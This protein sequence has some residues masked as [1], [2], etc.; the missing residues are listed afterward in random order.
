MNDRQIRKEGRRKRRLA[1]AAGAPRRP[2]SFG[3]RVFLFFFKAGLTL[4]MLLALVAGGA[5]MAIEAGALD[6]TLKARAEGALNGAVGPRYLA[7]VGSTAIR[8]AHNRQIAI[9]ARKVVMKDQDTGRVVSETGAIRL[10]LDPF[11]LFQGEL[12][13]TR[14][15]ADNVRF[16]TAL[17]STGEGLDLTRARVD[18][19]P[20][21][22]DNG[23]AQLD[24]FGGFIDRARTDALEIRGMELLAAGPDGKDLSVGKA[25]F[26]LE[27]RDDSSLRMDGALDIKGDAVPFTILAERRLGKVASLKASVHEVPLLHFGP[28]PDWRGRTEEKLDAT[29]YAEISAIRK[30]QDIFPEITLSARVNPGT[31]TLH[32]IDQKL[33]GATVEAVYDF[34]KNSVEF[35]PSSV[36]FGETNLPFTGGLIDL[37]RIRPDA[38]KGFGIDFLV[39]GGKVYTEG[40]GAAPADMDAQASGYYL[41]ADQELVFDQMTASTRLG[42]IIGSMKMKFGGKEPE[43]SFVA[44]TPSA[45]MQTVKQ[46]WPFWIA[47]NARQWVSD[48]LFAGSVSNGSI[49]VFVPADRQRNADGTL[50]LSDDQL[51]INFDVTNARVN[52]AGDIPPLRGTTGHIQLKGA[53]LHAEIKSGTSYFPTDRSVNIDGGTFSIPD[54]SQEPLM[55]E[56]DVTVSGAA[57]AVAEL[58]TYRPIKFLGRTGLKPEDLAGNIRAHVKARF[59]L[60]SEDDVDPTWTADMALTNVD[61]MKPVQGRR[62][63]GLTG[64][65]EVTPAEA[66]LEAKGEV[67]GVPMEL[68]ATE[69]FD[70]AQRARRERLM[71]LTLDTAD[72]ARLFPNLEQVV[73]GPVKAKVSL[74]EDGVQQVEADLVAATLKVPGSGWTKGAGIPAR[75][76]FEVHPSEDRVE[77]RNLA[78]EGDG[79]GVAG[80]IE[81]RN[82][83]LIVA[84]FDRVKLA[85]NDNFALTVRPIRSGFD[86][87]VSGAAL[88]ARAAIDRFRNAGTSD[89]GGQKSLAL[90][91]RAKV[92]TIYGFGDETLRNVDL[93][94]A[95]LSPESGKLQLS[96]LSGGGQ[97]VVG[98]MVEDGRGRFVQ[99]TSGDAG[100]T[101]R[102]LGL[103]SRLQKG[104]LNMRLRPGKAGSWNGNV[105]IRDFQLANEER[106]QTI[107]STPAGKDGRSLNKAV[108]KDI[109]VRSEKFQRGFAFFTYNNGT[110]AI[111]NGVLRGTQVGATFQGTIRDAAGKMDVTGTFMPAYGLNRLFGE[112]PVIGILLGNGRDRGLLGIT[113]KLTGPF[114]KPNL[115]INP[116]SIIAPGI[117]RQVFEFQ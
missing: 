8:F 88:D 53:G 28:G 111:E 114:E 87:A 76:R 116:L 19:I 99:L 46:L 39:S 27:R 78:V 73:G 37:D 41:S 43:I 61:V 35:L 74:K 70:D 2:R 13:I 5:F 92:D 104:L 20:G 57:D 110:L 26:L 97:P 82:G 105:D 108:K 25:H 47:P 34:N 58:I 6:K 16:D 31:L 102:F 3:M 113:F 24:L 91:L 50:H 94:Y 22:V 18:Q 23:F 48:N 14:I 59:G 55:A 15:E 106:L 109:D 60:N 90:V 98:Q 86:V 65:A 40:S 32:G 17:F 83:K 101:F 7:T 115:T 30:T 12:T 45:Q 44:Q 80:E 10:A 4:V 107:V 36:R 103:Y 79:F 71:S 49:E 77:V 38:G 93:A 52:I 95:P 112:L 21:L 54:F 29:A 89:S 85:A 117:F 64:T 81:A 11:R 72:I 42:S 96:A 33:D 75:A 84:S 69:P 51:N 63:T 66:V 100:S 9:E 1:K 68:N 56:T 67:D 62:L